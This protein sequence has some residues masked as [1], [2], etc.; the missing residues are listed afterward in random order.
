MPFLI[1]VIIIIKNNNHKNN[2]HKM[3]FRKLNWNVLIQWTL[4][5]S[6]LIKHK[7]NKNKIDVPVVTELRGPL[8]CQASISTG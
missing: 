7:K 4:G 1:K 5:P 8:A 6:L 3:W 2:N